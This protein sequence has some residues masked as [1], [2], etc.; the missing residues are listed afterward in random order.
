MYIEGGAEAGGSASAD[1]SAMSSDQV[2][3]RYRDTHIQMHV[4][5]ARVYM[6]VCACSRVRERG[7]GER[8]V[9]RSVAVGMPSPCRVCMCILVRECVFVV[10]VCVRAR[11]L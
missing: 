9:P 7:Y 8:L 5:R 4:P 1:E 11:V 2:E 10:C 3:I 6:R